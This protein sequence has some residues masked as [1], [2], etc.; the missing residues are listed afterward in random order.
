MPRGAA[1][2]Y[3]LR[4]D[5]A[6]PEALTSQPHDLTEGG[7]ISSQAPNCLTRGPGTVSL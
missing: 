1:A 6:L 5:Q 7:R 2:P 4:R 3:V